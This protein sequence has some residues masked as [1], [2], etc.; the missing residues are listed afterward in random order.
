MRME[1]QP[2]YSDN[3]S[4]FWN[5]LEK[6]KSLT[7]GSVYGGGEDNSAGPPEPKIE[8]TPRPTPREKS[9]VPRQYSDVAME[10]GGIRVNITPVMTSEISYTGEIYYWHVNPQTV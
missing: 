10:T 2:K 7:V 3:W 9:P 1:H 4:M 6:V 8:K 5:D